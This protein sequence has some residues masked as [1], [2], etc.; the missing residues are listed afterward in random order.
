MNFK[1]FVHAE[2]KDPANSMTIE[3]DDLSEMVHYALECVRQGYQTKTEIVRDKE[4]PH[5]Q[6]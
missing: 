4:A 6:M 5:E 2:H 3:C 1:Y